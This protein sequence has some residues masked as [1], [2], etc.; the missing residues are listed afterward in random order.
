M[1]LVNYS[2]TRS[3]S[4]IKLGKRPSGSPMHRCKDNIRMVLK[5]ISINAW[6]WVDSAQ[7]KDYRGTL[8]NSTLNL[9]V[10]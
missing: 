10:S 2:R 4:I 5:E 3:I 8:V 6:N 7:D 1:E 9:R